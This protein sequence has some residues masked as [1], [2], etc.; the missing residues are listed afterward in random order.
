MRY[1]VVWSQGNN[2]M[3]SFLA[4]WRHFS[5]R[6]VIALFVTWRRVMTSR[7]D[8]TSSCCYGN[9]M[10][11]ILKSFETPQAIAMLLWGPHW[12][13]VVFWK[14]EK[15]VL[16]GFW[17]LVCCYCL[18]APSLIMGSV[19]LCVLGFALHKTLVT[20]IVDY[21]ST[22]PTGWVP[23]LLTFAAWV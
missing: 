23:V 5:W 2:A 3:T 13:N 7:R 9:V 19:S 8:V 10:A 1:W 4:T 17:H 12:W 15:G 14:A 18:C 16:Y 6:D 20:V 11:G 22:Q 21:V